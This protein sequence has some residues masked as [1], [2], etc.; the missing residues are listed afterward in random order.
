[1]RGNLGKACNALGLFAVGAREFRNLGLER[2]QKL[3]YLGLALLTHGLRPANPCLN[4]P[5]GIFNH[6]CIVL[7]PQDT[8]PPRSG[9]KCVPACSGTPRWFAVL[10]V[11][12]KDARRC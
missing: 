12:G 2:A 1:M 9:K 5:D 7:P 3:S 11:L 4:L 6:G 8:P 10:F